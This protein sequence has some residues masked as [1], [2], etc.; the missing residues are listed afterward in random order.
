[1]IPQFRSMVGARIWV[2]RTSGYM[3]PM[4]GVILG[5]LGL[6]HGRKRDAPTGLATAG[7]VLGI[8]SLIPA[9]IILSILG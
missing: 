7:L 4:L 8:I 2:F 1:M 6:S 5:G 3:P 9:V